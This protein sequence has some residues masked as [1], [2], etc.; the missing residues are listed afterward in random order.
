[1][2]RIN[3]PDQ[4][5]ESMGRIMGQINGPDQWAGS[6]GR[7]NGPDQWALR[8]ATID[9]WMGSSLGRRD[10]ELNA[11]PLSDR[12]SCR[13]KRQEHDETV[14]VTNRYFSHPMS[15]KERRKGGGRLA[16]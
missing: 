11:P 9:W 6:M 4:W 16:N 10:F 14:I 1:M 15:H 12:A 3:G 13:K 2:G 5:A 8:D 7:T